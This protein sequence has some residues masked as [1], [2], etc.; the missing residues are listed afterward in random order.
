MKKVVCF[1]FSLLMLIAF[2][3]NS[4][5][6]NW[7]YASGNYVSSAPVKPTGLKFYVDY[8]AITTYGSNPFTVAFD[9][10]GSYNGHVSAVA[11]YPAPSSEYPDHFRINTSGS[12]PTGAVGQTFYYTSSGALIGGTYPMDSTSIY[13]CKISLN[14]DTS[15]FNV[16]GSFSSTYLKKVIRHEIGHVFLLKH[17]SYL[18]FSSVMHQGAPASYISSTVTTDDRNNIKAKW[19]S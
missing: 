12:L 17:P 14:S 19:G 15:A 10:N 8:S 5:A 6:A 11:Q 3:L 1:A 18:Y 4:Y 9:W 16:N 2:P 7:Y 13:K